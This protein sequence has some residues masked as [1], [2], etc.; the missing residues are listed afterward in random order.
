VL[1]VAK[2]LQDL[3]RGLDRE[4]V[5]LCHDVSKAWLEQVDRVVRL[6]HRR[7]ADVRAIANLP[8]WQRPP[9]PFPVGWRMLDQSKLL[10]LQHLLMGDVDATHLQH[11]AY[12]WTDC[13]HGDRISLDDPVSARPLLT[14][15]R[16]AGTKPSQVVVWSEG[17]DVGE[18][19]EDFETILGGLPTSASVEHRSGRAPIYLGLVEAGG[20]SSASCMHRAPRD[21]IRATP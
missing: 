12:A 7:H 16:D 4:V 9:M 8:P 3:A 2:C 10:G 14:W 5:A 18:A 15:F 20:S 11:L 1:D 6:W 13:L 19:I 21:W 17:V